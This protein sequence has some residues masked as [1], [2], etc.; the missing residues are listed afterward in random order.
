MYTHTNTPKSTQ[1]HKK[2]HVNASTLLADQSSSISARISSVARAVGRCIKCSW[3]SGYEKAHF[4]STFP[5]THYANLELP[6]LKKKKA[7]LQLNK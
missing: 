2:L 6:W 1:Q 3:E 5:F 4:N 7:S